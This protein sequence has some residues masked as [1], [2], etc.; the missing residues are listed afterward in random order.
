MKRACVLV[1]LMLILSTTIALSQLTLAIGNAN[2]HPVKIGLGVD[3]ISGSPNLL[4]KVFLSKEVAA[5]VIV[6]VSIDSPGGS[7]P[8]GFTKVTGTELRGGLSLLYHLT[9][10]QVSPYVGAEAIFQT[11]KNA[12]FFATEPDAKNSVP[13]VAGIWGLAAEK[14]GP[15]RAFGLGVP[16]IEELRPIICR[17]QEEGKPDRL[18]LAKNTF[19]ICDRLGLTHAM[20]GNRNS[21]N[22]RNGILRICRNT[23]AG[24]TA[25]RT[26]TA[27][28][29]RVNVGPGNRKTF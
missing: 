29:L 12:G 17:G 22:V 19:D 3:G 25:A 5:Q 2:L 26:K 15:D 7:A 13:C 23:V 1:L 4:V 11:A 21:G 24:R 6:G 18:V 20:C 9:N 14:S 27:R 10:D 28:I 16:E 8:A